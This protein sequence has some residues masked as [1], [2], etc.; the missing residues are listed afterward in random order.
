M[1]KNL[2]LALGAAL[3][4]IVPTYVMAYAPNWLA[5][6]SPARLWVNLAADLTF[7]LS[8]FVLG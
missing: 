8:L 3:L 6:T 7:L 2:R 5:D 1:G 4:P